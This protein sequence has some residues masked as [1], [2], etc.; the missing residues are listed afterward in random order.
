MKTGYLVVALKMY[1]KQFLREEDD[2]KGMISWKQQLKPVEM[3]QVGSY[4][5]TFQGT[6]PAKPKVAEGDIWVDENVKRIKNLQLR[7][8]RFN[9][10]ILSS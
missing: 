9:I 10:L 8:T 6:T 7:L 5:L 4:L 3:A 2:G 1:L